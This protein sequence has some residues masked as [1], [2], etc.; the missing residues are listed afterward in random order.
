VYLHIGAPKTGTTY[1]QDRLTRNAAALRKRG[2]VVPTSSPLVSPALFHFRAA[3]DVLGQDWGGRPGHAEGAWGTLLKRVRRAPGSVVVSHEIFAPAQPDKVARIVGDLTDAMGGGELHV[4]YSARDLGRQLPAAWQESIKQ[5]RKWTFRRFLTRVERGHNWFFRAFDLPTVLEQWGALV[6]AERI[7]VV[8]VPPSGQGGDL[9]WLRMC[10]A[11]SID[12]SWAPAESRRSNQSLG[13]AETEVIRQL[14]QR[15]GRKT[16]RQAEFDELVRQFLAEQ[17]LSERPGIPVRLPPDRFPWAEKQAETWIGWLASSGVQLVGD[18]ADL[19]P[20]RPKTPEEG[21]E[22][23][24]LN[25]GRVRNKI[26]LNAA[27]DALA[28]MTQ[29]AAR[30]PDPDKTGLGRVR[31]GVDRIRSRQ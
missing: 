9:L 29:E 4:V 24:G 19:R 1:V 6:P 7:H 25:P 2:V 5:G 22:A 15:M 12:P 27:I 23:E 21:S 31:T 13:A 16:R 30:R 18:P 28:A 17:H 20:V 8:T 10:E 26:K 14:N 11:L 3:L